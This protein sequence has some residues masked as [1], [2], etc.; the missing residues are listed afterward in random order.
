MAATLAQLLD[1][2]RKEA[3][4]RGF[5]SVGVFHL[6]WAARILAPE[7]FDAWLQRY[8]IEP[9]PFIKMLENVLRPRRAGGGVPRDRHDAALLEE[10]VA[11]AGRIA[12]ERDQNPGV[13]HLGE[14]WK[15]LTEDPV[16]SLCDRFCLPWSPPA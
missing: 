11:R 5:R 2:A 7:S 1:H 8:R 15:E 13:E 6:L 16:V 9:A 3:Q 12:A 4:Q 14:V 10:A